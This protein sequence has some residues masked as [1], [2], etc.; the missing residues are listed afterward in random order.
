[1][2]R[3]DKKRQEERG[4]THWSGDDSRNLLLVEQTGQQISSP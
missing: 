4:V 3:E 1:M 2:E